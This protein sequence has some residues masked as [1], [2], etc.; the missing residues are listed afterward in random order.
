MKNEFNLNKMG[1][2]NKKAILFWCVIFVLATG[3]SLISFSIFK[4]LLTVKL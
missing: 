3:I 4:E 2:I 1:L